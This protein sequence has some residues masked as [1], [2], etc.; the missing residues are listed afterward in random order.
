MRMILMNFW[1]RHY[2]WDSVVIHTVLQEREKQ[3][4]LKRWDRYS[5][6]KS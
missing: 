1:F 2:E 4:P 6:A 5:V 3:N